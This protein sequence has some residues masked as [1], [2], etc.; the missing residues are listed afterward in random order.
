MKMSLSIIETIQLNKFRVMGDS[1]A[2]Q[3]VE[4]LLKSKGREG[5]FPFLAELQYNAQLP[6]AN[7]SPALLD[8]WQDVNRNLDWENQESINLAHQVS[9][10]HMHEILH[11]LGFLSLPYCYA[12]A[13]GAKV[14]IN[15]KK[16]VENPGI[17]LADTAEFVLNLIS[18]NAFEPL[19]K[20]LAS[21]FKTRLIHAATR[22]F[23]LKYQ[24][25]D[26]QS[27]LPVNQEDMAGTL[28][29]FSLMVIKGIAKLNIRL[30][31][32][33]KVAFIHL[34]NAIGARLGL[35]AELIMHSYEDTEKLELTIRNRHFKPSDEGQKLANALVTYYQSNLPPFVPKDW[36]LKQ[37]RFMLGDKVSTT[38]KLSGSGSDAPPNTNILLRLMKWQMGNSISQMKGR[39]A[40]SKF[41][42]NNKVKK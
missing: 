2:D 14:L 32:N 15:S 21:I 10:K 24:S 41:L 27:G 29:S 18:P 19:G 23:I 25:W 7:W 4:E 31:A 28:L 5:F 35:H 6:K 12:A 40:S 38:L 20:G 11:V 1:L 42:E 13:D 17:R 26:M 34:W 36:P 3:A 9:D 22:Y 16:I 30:N 33:E 39:M 8:L 37:M